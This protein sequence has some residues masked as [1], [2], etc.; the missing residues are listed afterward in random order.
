MC[1]QYKQVFHNTLTK[2]IADI[3]LKKK[4][5]EERE[6]N[7]RKRQRE[8]EEEIE[9]KAKREKEW[10]KEWEVCHFNLQGFVT[11][12]VDN[13]D[14]R[15]DRIDSWRDFQQ[16]GSKKKKKKAAGVGGLKPPKLKQEK[17]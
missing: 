17:R 14:T 5:M 9:A 4:Q 11:D 6:H 15:S 8:M 16:K 2:V 1:F 12:M 7:E 3:E 10:K 13:Q